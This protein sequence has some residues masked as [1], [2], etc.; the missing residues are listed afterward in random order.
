M[1][2]VDPQV[3]T[4]TLQERPE[5]SESISLKPDNWKTPIAPDLLKTKSLKIHFGLG[6]MS[7]GVDAITQA[8]QDGNE[9]AIRESVAV[10]DAV[11]W[12][13]RKQSLMLDIARQHGG[14]LS[15]EAF[16]VL[17]T[18]SRMDFQN[19]PKTIF[20]KKFSEKYINTHLANT[21]ENGNN[22][23]SQVPQGK[24]YENAQIFQNA[25]M[26]NQVWQSF[27][28]NAKSEYDATVGYGRATW[29]VVENVIPFMSWWSYGSVVKNDPGGYL[30]L[31][32]KSLL[33]K[34]QYIKSLPINE[35]IRV[36]EQAFN[37][38][39]SQ[40][41]HDALHFAKSLVSYSYSD[42]ALD[43]SVGV[44]DLSILPVG[45]AV[46]AVKNAVK[47]AV[48]PTPTPDVLVL[49]PWNEIRAAAMAGQGPL[50]RGETRAAP[51]P[52]SGEILEIPNLNL[53]GGKLADQPEVPFNI[54]A[55]NALNEELK[56]DWQIGD[57]LPNKEQ[58][59]RAWSRYWDQGNVTDATKDAMRALRDT[60]R[61]TEGTYLDGASV[62]AQSGDVA[63]AGL[64]DGMKR[65]M[66]MHADGEGVISLEK[67]LASAYNPWNFFGNGTAM[68]NR[69]AHVLVDTALINME[70]LTKTL[71]L[72][73]RGQ[74]LPEEAL[75]IALKEAEE[76]LS[77]YYL[78]RINDGFLDMVHIPRQVNPANVDTVVMRLGKP[79]Q[80]T[81]FTSRAEAKFHA[82][83]VYSLSPGEYNIYQQGTSFYIG[84]PTVAQENTE[85]VLSAVFNPKNATPTGL[86]RNSYFQWLRSEDE[87]MPRD[88]QAQ[89]K[90]AQHS[91]QAL[92]RA[93][94]DLYETNIRSLGK[95]RLQ[96]V[97]DILI[98]NRDGPNAAGSRKNFWYETA[99][100][101]E[102]AF[103]DKHKKP[104]TEAQTNAY[105]TYRQLSDFDALLGNLSAYRDKAVK[106]WEQFALKVP[107][108]DKGFF[109]GVARN[110][111]PWNNQADARIL[112]YDKTNNK[113]TTVY[114]NDAATN[115]NAAMNRQM[116]DELVDRGYQVIQVADP[117]TRPFKQLGAEGVNLDAEVNFVVTNAFERKPLSWRQVDYEAGGHVIYPYRFYV[118]Q[119]VI[120]VGHGGREHYYGDNA[121][122]NFATEAEAKKYMERL[123]T[124]TEMLKHNHPDLEKYL[125][126]N[127]PYDRA[128]FQ[129][130]FQDGTF[131]MDRKFGFTEKGHDIFESQEALSRAH[132]NVVHQSS[133]PYDMTSQLDR[134]FLTEKSNILSTVVEQRGGIYQIAPGKQLD[135]FPALQA[136]L[137]QRL[138]S[139]FMN[140]YKDAAVKRWIEEFQDVLSVGPGGK[141]KTLDEL[142][143]NS[144]A[145]LYDDGVFASVGGTEQ[146]Y[147]LAA[148]RG[149]QQ[150]IR[151][152]L[153][154]HSQLG[155]SLTA[156]QNQLVSSIYNKAGQSWSNWIS[157]HA[158]PYIKDPANFFRAVAFH[159]KLGSFNPVQY[160]LQAQ[161][162]GHSIAI[163]G[164]NGLK[165]SA[166]AAMMRSL[167]H[168][169]DEGVIKA[170]AK[171][172]TNFGWKEKEFLEMYEAFRGTGLYE[173]MGE[174]AFK[175][176]LW[177]GKLFRSTTG[178]WLDKGSMFFNEGERMVRLTAF[179]TAFK[180]F[181]AGNKLG[182]LGDTEIAA[183]LNRADLLSMNMTRASLSAFQRGILSIPTQF[184]TFHLRFA[185]QM[186]GKRLTPMEKARAM[187][188]YGAMYGVPVTLGIGGP[189]AS[190][191]GAVTG[192]MNGGLKDAVIQGAAATVGMWPVA[193][194]IRAEAIKRGIDLSP[195]WVQ[196]LMEGLPH[197]MLSM[198]AGKEYNTGR[199]APG[200]NQMIRD[201]MR[202]P[203]LW[204][205]AGG[206]SGKIISDLFSST[207]PLMARTAGMVFGGDNAPQVHAGDLAKILRNVSTA[208]TAVKVWGIMQYGKH[209][210]KEHRELGPADTLD[211]LMAPLGLTPQQM[212][213]T[214]IK[215]GITKDQKKVQ[216][217]YENKAME[218]YRI[219]I[220][221]S[222][223]GD[224]QKADAHWKNAR[225]YIILGDFNYR[226]QRGIMRKA[227]DSA[228]P[229]MDSINQNFMRKRPNSMYLNQFKQHIVNPPEQVEE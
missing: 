135:P 218:E 229:L 59:Q 222:Q 13:Y 103:M 50:P 91:P 193:E 32:G 223:Q 35:G 56:A 72:A 9:N 73:V 30:R 6:E 149:A 62:L 60:V 173:V 97:E 204:E 12:N 160:I 110:G 191:A 48:T 136:G 104:P 21:L 107:G 76:R 77:R 219:S 20:E 33:E 212:H 130:V 17:N 145:A 15:P 42:Q 126:A 38:I 170:A 184:M 147:R 57:S 27:Y 70:N 201:I 203:N 67:D 99:A 132:P 36:A 227:I 68:S 98:I 213:D 89:K 179:A 190:V 25:L 202:D 43:D 64:F 221:Y 34:L 186:M 210:T 158:L 41:W 90:V 131:S 165:G 199:F 146:T 78:G 85:R 195:L 117:K 226:D 192:F 111:I 162:M 47:R 196:A 106:G 108:V 71:G 88:L 151:N 19:D 159:T 4:I 93:I 65:F 174:A 139:M 96:E 49:P 175:G 168:T 144:Y 154:V 182:K 215:S 133:N 171:K 137:N 214:W 220:Q 101:F 8:L 87:L 31:P 167:A 61:A 102:K 180:E 114:K 125:S 206:A 161:T 92:K 95:K 118:K 198:V 79:G 5:D 10:R 148:A 53:K 74:R 209:Y 45:K 83:D 23:Y 28:E 105:Y 44:L 143:R 141:Y 172:M 55:K 22:V 40:N 14:Q 129:K 224:H 37:E 86:T 11:D 177:D 2:E 205:A 81:P 176:D 200:N 39:K 63:R 194:D 84:I 94:T 75:A 178:I 228:A 115:P 69:R 152:F 121:L 208:D 3:G 24:L 211:A 109:E 18:M 187:L 54:R 120:A 119:P 181:R 155:E 123:N 142:R 113:F 216:S 138:K 169:M 112:I 51:K 58:F 122:M 150:S 166:A 29:D 157:D 189:I 100:D 7:P 46:R 140:D 163:A 225:A 1:E 128:Q 217:Y 124:A 127:L 207:F 156:F 183:I 164:T 66:A 26:E 185:E 82:D 80:A 134:A 197:M 188:W 52:P 153:G 16:D 116:L